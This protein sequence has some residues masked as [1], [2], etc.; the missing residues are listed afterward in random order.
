MT[1]HIVK[2]GTDLVTSFI[3]VVVGGNR[4]QFRER[5]VRRQ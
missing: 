2:E 5:R 3:M 4:H 1:L